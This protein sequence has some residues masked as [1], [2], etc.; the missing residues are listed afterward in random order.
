MRSMNRPVA[1]SAAL[2][3][4]LFPG[5]PALASDRPPE[6][7]GAIS[8]RADRWETSARFFNSLIEDQIATLQA[9]ANARRGTAFRLPAVLPLS[10][11]ADF[12][13]RWSF[14]PARLSL[15]L[16]LTD[17]ARMTI[18]L[19]TSSWSSRDARALREALETPGLKTRRT[20]IMPDL[21]SPAS[22]SDIV[23]QD[24]KTLET[25]TLAEMLNRIAG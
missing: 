18:P 7:H 23:V 6:T 24:Q 10:D 11:V 22:P 9:S 19:K 20:L 12:R 25:T 21:D 2:A 13:E 5:V 4:L 16:K 15:D 8:E 17:G 1:A 3:A 14:G